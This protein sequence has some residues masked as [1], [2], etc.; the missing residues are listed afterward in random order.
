MIL[1]N[2][3]LFKL[4]FSCEGV[5]LVGQAI[6]PAA[7]IPVG[8][9]RGQGKFC[10]LSLRLRC[11]AG[12]LMKPHGAFSSLRTGRTPTRMSAAGKIACPTWVGLA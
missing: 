4:F 7:G 8:D 6:L 2:V 9:L 3:H 10:K 1:Q 12:L 11:F 5:Q